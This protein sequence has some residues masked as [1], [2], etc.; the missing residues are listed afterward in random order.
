METKEYSDRSAIGRFF[1]SLFFSGSAILFHMNLTTLS[2]TCAV[3]QDD[4]LGTLE[5]ML[6][7]ARRGGLQ[8]AS[9]QADHVPQ[10]L[11]VTLVLQAQEAER[12][13]LFLARLGNAIGVADVQVIRFG[14]GGLYSRHG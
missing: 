11:N 13:E 5:S 8:L 1:G 3:G 14:V 7:I 6:S 12:L 10:A 2:L 4:P 9:M